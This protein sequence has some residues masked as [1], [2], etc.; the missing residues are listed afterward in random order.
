[1]LCDDD[2]N[3][4]DLRNYLPSQPDQYDNFHLACLFT[5]IISNELSTVQWQSV[6]LQKMTEFAINLNL[7]R[8]LSIL[9]R[10]K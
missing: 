8:F 2:G 9:S 4:I 6:V 3:K 10:K 5:N 7:R 1:M